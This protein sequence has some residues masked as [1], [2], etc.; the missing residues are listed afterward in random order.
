MHL[1]RIMISPWN[2]N[3]LM[4]ILSCVAQWGCVTNDTLY[5]NALVGWACRTLIW[6]RNFT[7]LYD[8]KCS[9]G[10]CLNAYVVAVELVNTV[11]SYAVH[12]GNMIL[13]PSKTLLIVTELVHCIIALLVQLFKELLTNTF[14]MPITRRVTGRLPNQATLTHKERRQLRHLSRV[15]SLTQSLGAMKCNYL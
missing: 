7:A 8:M 13:I 14:N 5:I 15:K 11:V 4:L 2:N 6:T 9:V 1:L 3:K 12:T 10:L